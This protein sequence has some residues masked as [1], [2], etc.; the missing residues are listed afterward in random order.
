MPA[1]A[2]SLAMTLAIPNSRWRF[3][4]SA[5]RRWSAELWC[6]VRSSFFGRDVSLEVAKT[7]DALVFTPR[8]T[9]TDTKLAAGG[10]STAA[11]EPSDALNAQHSSERHSHLW[12]ITAVHLLYWRMYQHRWGPSEGWGWTRTHW[13]WWPH[14]EV[15]LHMDCALGTKTPDSPVCPCCQTNLRT[16]VP[17]WTAMWHVHAA[18]VACTEQ[19]W[20][21][22]LALSPWSCAYHI[23]RLCTPRAWFSTIRPQTALRCLPVVTAEISTEQ[24]PGSIEIN[25]GSMQYNFV[26]GNWSYVSFVSELLNLYFLLDNYYIMNIIWTYEQYYV[27]FS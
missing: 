25:S 7:F 10:R 26:Q 16:P 1:L 15:G 20:S 18:S 24:E 3:G 21:A 27:N 12:G 23:C 11:R 9:T 5:A 4:R 14:R 6:F 17:G 2:W 19:W 22:H 13:R 8:A